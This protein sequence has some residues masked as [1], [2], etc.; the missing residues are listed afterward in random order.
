VLLE[1][2]K[3][4]VPDHAAYCPFCR[5]RATPSDFNT[6]EQAKYLREVALAEVQRRVEQGLRTSAARFNR[7]PQRGFITI[8]MDVNLPPHTITATPVAQEAMTLHI[9][10]EE[11]GCRFTVVG[12]AYFCP[13]CGHNSASHTFG[14]SLAAARAA[15]TS[16]PEIR[17]TLPDRD[18]AAQVMRALIEGNLG[19][20]V[21]AFQRFA[22][23]QYSG[24]PNPTEQPRRNAFQNLAEGSRLWEAAGGSAYSAILDPQELAALHRLFQQR[25]LLAH[26]EGLVD[27][28]YLD[29]SGDLA[30]AVGQR[31]V[32]REQT[33][34]RLADL[35]E[36]LVMGLRADL[37]ANT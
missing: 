27:Q 37:S 17:S 35:L 4:K 30:Y 5:R 22:E 25:H 9:V 13:A 6:P 28:D 1:D 33:V 11:C 2:W 26:R 31:L 29:R 10:C 7:Q 34:L 15:I 23:A 32:I 19:A 3:A 21:T 36:K 14:Q 12:A 20:L 24:L 8:R 16:L 18:T